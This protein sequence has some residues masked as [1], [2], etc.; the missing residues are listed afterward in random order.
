MIVTNRK[1]LIKIIFVSLFFLW[2]VI[3]FHILYVYIYD[4]S[5]KYPVKWGTLVEAGIWPAFYLPYSSNIDKYKFYQSLLFRGCITPYVSWTKILYKDDLCK[6][7][8]DNFRDFYVYLKDNN[9]WSDGVPISLDDVYFTYNDVIVN[10]KFKF[11]DLEKFR[12]IK[13]EKNKDFIKVTFPYPSKDNLIFFTNFV[14]P[15]HILESKDKRYYLNNFPNELVN[16]TCA[17]LKLFKNDPHSILFD[18]KECKDYYIDNFQYK[19]F[20]NE[21]Q[22]VDYIDS[23][24]KKIVDFYFLDK[25]FSGYVMYPYILNNYVVIFFNNKSQNIDLR[26]KKNFVWFLTKEILT[27]TFYRYFV[28]V[29][30]FFKIDIDSYNIDNYFRSKE[31]ENN[32]KII[33]KKLPNLPKEIILSWKNE[34]YFDKDIDI[35]YTLNFYLPVGC[36]KLGVIYNSWDIYWLRAYKKWSRVA[37]YNVSPR[38]ANIKKGKNIYQIVCVKKWNKFYYK[39]VLWWKNLPKEKIKVNSKENKIRLI[40]YED[41]AIKQI[42]ELLVKKLKQKWLI[43]YFDIKSVKNANEL[44]GILVWWNYDIIIIGLYLWLKRDIWDIFISDDP[45][46]NPSRYKNLELKSLYSQYL[47][48]QGKTKQILQ[49]QIEKIYNQNLP[50]YFVW[51]YIDRYWQRAEIKKPVFPKRLYN[52]W[53]KKEYIRNV[54]IIYKPVLKKEVI[55]NIHNFIKWLKDNVWLN[56]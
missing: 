1:S 50:L 4:I 36:D 47:I 56:I 19:F 16:N 44:K 46:I 37:Y 52:L 25:E 14:L 23:Q 8:T 10:N 40:Y 29:N 18:L 54:K 43:K 48:A 26:F 21:N 28:K 15:K 17:T 27:W 3:T 7:K 33:E 13:I 34:Y 9:F 55:F 5:P 31:I 24:K 12:N 53:L 39:L 42:V 49:D 41:K 30:D 45:L 32:I 11:P 38:F 20:D 51:K 35:K 2:C 22:M 6:I